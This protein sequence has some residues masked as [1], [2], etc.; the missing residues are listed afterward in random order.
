ML[1]PAKPSIPY[2]NLF[3]YIPESQFTKDLL[4]KLTKKLRKK[5]IKR[6]RNSACLSIAAFRGERKEKGNA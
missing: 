5:W 6:E 4:P 3:K 2:L 1:R